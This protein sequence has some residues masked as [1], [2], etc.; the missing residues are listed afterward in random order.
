MGNFLQLVGIISILV[1]SYYNVDFAIDTV[2]YYYNWSINYWQELFR[3][4]ANSFNSKG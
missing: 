2:S 3:E 1:F 4:F